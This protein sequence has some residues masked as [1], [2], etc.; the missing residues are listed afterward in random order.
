MKKFKF[1][2]AFVLLLYC[3][4]VAMADELKILQPNGGVYKQGTHMIIKWDYT[5]LTNLTTP[6]EKEIEIWLARPSSTLAAPNWV[7]QIKKVD[8]HAGSTSWTVDATPGSYR[9]HFYKRNIPLAGSWAVSE[10]FTVEENKLPLKLKSKVPIALPIK[11]INPLQGQV[12]YSGK[13][14]TIQWDKSVV[15]AYPTVLLQVCWPDGRPA[16]GSFP[17]SNTGSYVWQINET[18]ENSLRVS[19]FT[20]DKKYKGLSG[21]FQIKLPSKLPL[22]APRQIMK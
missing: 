5:I 10:L 8:V 17:T 16:A 22:K 1:M 11:I 13:S 6:Q 3:G 18:A 19:V 21:T 12:Y 9:I 15:A 4:N 7:K 14:M 20:S 2:I